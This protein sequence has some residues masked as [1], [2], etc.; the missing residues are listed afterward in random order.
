VVNLRAAHAAGIVEELVCPS[1]IHLC[2]V[3][4]ERTVQ[5]RLTPLSPEAVESSLALA[6]NTL[7]WDKPDRLAHNTAVLEALLRLANIY[8]LKI[9]TDPANIIA[10]L[11]R[12]M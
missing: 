12:I 3:E 6:D 2:F 10:T 11:D 5:T 4:R 8:S 1:A 7:Y 9:G